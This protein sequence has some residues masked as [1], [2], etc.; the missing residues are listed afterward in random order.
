MRLVFFIFT[1]LA[2]WTWVEGEPGEGLIGRITAADIFG[3]LLIFSA[4][5]FILLKR[6]K[7]FLFP[8]LYVY[9]MPVL[10]VFLVSGFV[11]GNKTIALF[12]VVIHLFILLVSLSII[13]LS[14]IVDEEE[15]KRYLVAVLYG[16]SAVAVLGILHF[17][18]FSSLFSGSQG[19][20]SGT[21]RN[22]GQAGA[23]FGLFIALFAP[24]FMSRY[25][26]F[27]LCRAI[28]LLAIV[29]ALLLTFKRSFWIGT[30]SG[31][32]FSLI[33]CLYL[34]RLSMVKIALATIFTSAMCGI[35][36]AGVFS[37]AVDNVAGVQGR[38]DRKMTG[39]VVE[40]FMDGFFESNIEKSITAFH[41]SPVIGIGLSNYRSQFG[42]RYEIH[43]TWLA[44]LAYSGVLGVLAAALF[45]ALVVRRM[46]LAS[47]NSL[48]R[49]QSDF[50]ILLVFFFFG[51]LIA[52][53][54]TYPLR[55]RELWIYI[56]LVSI[57][58]M[59]VSRGRA[60]LL[61]TEDE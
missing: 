49:E 20:L 11:A 25:L 22:T 13:N 54:Y 23:Y 3:M 38:F 18:F 14:D 21:F 61:T 33:G 8:S 15:I 50:L 47:R 7:R 53:L 19:G 26:S 31:L 43:G 42:G 37:F 52:W 12:E 39:D 5:I 40:K 16:A 1:V 30:I 58:M 2:G 60:R 55:K 41:S 44:L 35:V 51:L 24:A 56:T 36:L 46:Y 28:A 32:V 17:F 27:N 48:S 6:D 45:F 4:S 34:R 29:V 57:L 9:Y 10:L 59:N